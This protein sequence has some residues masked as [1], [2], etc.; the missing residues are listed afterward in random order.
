VRCLPGSHAGTGE[1]VPTGDA[2]AHDG[3]DGATEA[4]SGSEAADTP[5]RTTATVHARAVEAGRGADVPGVVLELTD[6]QG[7]VAG[8]CVTTREGCTIED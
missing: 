8:V 2:A 4:G 7:R 1:D 5:A 3:A 6:A